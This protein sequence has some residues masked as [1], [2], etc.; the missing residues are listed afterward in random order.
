MNENDFR[1]EIRQLE[2]KI[3]SLERSHDQKIESMNRWQNYK[4]FAMSYAFFLI[5]FV[6]LICIKVS[7]T[8]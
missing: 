4:L 5:F 7:L 6:T 1:F 2:H 3:D 8:R